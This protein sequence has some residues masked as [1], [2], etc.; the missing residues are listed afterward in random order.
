MKIIQIQLSNNSSLASIADTSFF[1]FDTFDGAKA[2]VWTAAKSA[3][4]YQ[5]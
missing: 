3:A 2:L 4:Q 5:P 1:L